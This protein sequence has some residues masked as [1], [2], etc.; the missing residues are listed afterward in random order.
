[1]LNESLEVNN[2]RGPE[3]MFGVFCELK[4]VSVS[5]VIKYTCN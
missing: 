4:L 3:Q 1:M 2:C 5:I